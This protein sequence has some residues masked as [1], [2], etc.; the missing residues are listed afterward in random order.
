MYGKVLE[1]ID[2]NDP[3]TIT[4][5]QPTNHTTYKT[6]RFQ[7][8]PAL[9]P[10]DRH[11]STYR[12]IINSVRARAERSPEQR[13]RRESPCMIYTCAFPFLFDVELSIESLTPS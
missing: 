5:Q 13:T 2:T 6:A 10:V 12:I 4:H 11:H 9:Y 8:N 1:R 7:I 3:S